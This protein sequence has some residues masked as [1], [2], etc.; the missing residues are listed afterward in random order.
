M[1]EIEEDKYIEVDNKTIILHTSPSE[2]PR[3]TPTGKI[4]YAKTR[5]YTQRYRKE[6]EQTTD[7][8]GNYIVD[9]KFYPKC[10]KREGSFPVFFKNQHLFSLLRKVYTEIYKCACKRVHFPHLKILFRSACALLSRQ[11]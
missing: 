5:V 2:L 8:R 3:L 9:F 4:S 6:W 7:F 10:E 1:E 11:I